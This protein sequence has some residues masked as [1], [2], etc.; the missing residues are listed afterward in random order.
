MCRSSV[1]MRRMYL[2]LLHVEYN[3]LWARKRLHVIDI[4]VHSSILVFYRSPNHGFYFS[5][6]T[7]VITYSFSSFCSF[8]PCLRV[9]FA[10]LPF[11]VQIACSKLRF[12]ATEHL[13][14]A[15]HDLTDQ[16]IYRRKASGLH[17]RRTFVTHWNL[18][19]VTCKHGNCRELFCGLKGLNLGVIQGL[20]VIVARV[21]SELL[22]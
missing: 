17:R 22:H 10:W 4:K 11:F 20:A 2:Y 1:G 19:L 9:L 14:K 7:I 6:C 12:H 13:S 8:V 3:R 21:P 18:S 15:W 5:V 16:G